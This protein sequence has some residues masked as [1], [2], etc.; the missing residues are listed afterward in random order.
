M[1]KMY[2]VFLRAISAFLFFNCRQQQSMRTSVR[3]WGEW[4][5]AGLFFSRLHGHSE[6]QTAIRAKAEFLC[7][8]VITLI[9]WFEVLMPPRILVYFLQSC[10]RTSTGTHKWWIN[11]STTPIS[12]LWIKQCRLW[13]KSP[14]VIKHQHTIELGF[15]L[16]LFF[17]PPVIS[18]PIAQKELLVQ[19]IDFG[20]PSVPRGQGAKWR[21]GPVDRTVKHWLTGRC[22]RCCVKVTSSNYG[23]SASLC[24]SPD[25]V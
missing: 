21:P 24:W 2:R 15:F 23:S 4:I 5:A 9:L 16:F 22:R 17:F 6:S 3:E 14:Y 19:Y 1:C 10:N 25:Q 8:V 7:L 13:V 11:E 12:S 18:N 20:T